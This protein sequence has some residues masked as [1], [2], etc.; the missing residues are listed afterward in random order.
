ML[1]VD[2]VAAEVLIDHECG[3]VHLI[4]AAKVEA[5]PTR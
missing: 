5:E 3:C 2:Q 1:P 4:L